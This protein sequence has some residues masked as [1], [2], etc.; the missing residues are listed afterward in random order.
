MLFGTIDM[1]RQMLS[2]L[3]EMEQK[4]YATSVTKEGQIEW[5]K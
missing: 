3:D 2:E 5:Q 1:W 4:L